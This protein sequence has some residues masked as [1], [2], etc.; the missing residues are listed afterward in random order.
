M[1]TRGDFLWLMSEEAYCKQGIIPLSKVPIGSILH[2]CDG[3]HW[4]I[5]DS[6]LMEIAG[7]T[8]T[9]SSDEIVRRYYDDTH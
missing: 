4:I 6:G 3:S 2:K 7:V 8:P 5:N 1:D 9:R